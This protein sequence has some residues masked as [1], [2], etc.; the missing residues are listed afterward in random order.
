M[1]TGLTRLYGIVADPIGHVQTPKEMNALFA[2]EGVDGVLVPMHVR[3]HDLPAFVNG[4]RIMQ[5][6]GGI[7]ATVPHKPSMIAFCDRLEG[8]AAAI[9]AVN[10]VR[11]EADGT[12]VGAMLDG[13][14][15]IGGLHAAG[16]DVAGMNACLLGAGGAGAAIAF[17]LAEASVDQLT[18]VNR[19]RGKA[20]DLARRV[21]NRYPEVC[22][23]AG[24]P[25]TRERDLIVNATSLGLKPGDALPL[26]DLNFH[27][28]QIVS[29]AIMEPAETPFLAVARRS[30]SRIHPG[31]PMLKEQIRLMAVHL[32]A[33]P[34]LS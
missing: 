32:G 5:N 29:D 2:A 23:R 24:E 9:G 25:S 16:I 7:I 26:D 3:R 21:S 20:E 11:R 34:T 13:K 8:D 30:G 12:L 10:A 1:I 19:S 31:L 28:G 6:F 15:F 27:A 4:I 22:V 17:A 33:I 14:G 18:I